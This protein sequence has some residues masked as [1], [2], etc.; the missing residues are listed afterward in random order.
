MIE[1]ILRNLDWCVTDWSDLYR[2]VPCRQTKVV[3]SDRSKV[4][5]E[6]AERRCSSPEGLQSAIDAHVR[7][8]GT[9]ARCFVRPSGTENI[10]RV[11]AEAETQAKADAL[12]QA[13]AS[14]VVRFVDGDTR[15]TRG[16]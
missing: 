11:Y 12:A 1:T 15:V 6:D 4:K 10:V 16:F 5:T 9:S 7:E 8:S 2:D 13:V 14:T 3:V